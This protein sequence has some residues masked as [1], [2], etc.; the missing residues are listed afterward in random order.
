[1]TSRAWEDSK[2]SAT[3]LRDEMSISDVRE[4][5]VLDAAVDPVP[6]TFEDGYVFEYVR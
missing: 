4:S 3:G 6:Y 1:M 2:R 5:G